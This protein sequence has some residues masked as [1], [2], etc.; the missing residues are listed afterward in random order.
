M[1]HGSTYTSTLYQI[2]V[3]DLCI[4]HLLDD[5]LWYYII[6]CF[7]CVYVYLHCVSTNLLNFY[8]NNRLFIP[9]QYATWLKYLRR[10][11]IWYTYL[12]KGTCI[13]R[14]METIS[15]K[16]I[17]KHKSTSEIKLCEGQVHYIKKRIHKIIKRA[18]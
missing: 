14:A 1:F 17:R 15:E 10:P 12:V 6:F 3:P 8:T 9:L 5:L 16:G 7:W 11:P 2:R 18:F 13:C 4:K